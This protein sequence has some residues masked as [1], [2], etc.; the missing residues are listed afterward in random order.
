MRTIRAASIG[1]ALMA[2]AGA[3]LVATPARADWHGHYGH[4]GHYWHGHWYNGG[5]CWVPPAVV[6]APRPYY[7]A[8]PPAYYAPPPPVVYAPP[9]YAAPGIGIGVTIR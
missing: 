1:L 3:G 4:G 5:C 2:T 9:V 6:V 8:P 7:Y